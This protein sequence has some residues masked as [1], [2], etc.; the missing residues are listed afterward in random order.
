M[1]SRKGLVLDGNILLRA[2]FGTRVRQVLETYEDPLV[3]AVRM[4]ALGRPKNTFRIWLNGV[5]W[6]VPLR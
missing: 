1:N 2:V 3:S 5:Q 6:T 4:C